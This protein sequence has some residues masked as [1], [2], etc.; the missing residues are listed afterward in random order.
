MSQTTKTNSEIS[1]A[2]SSLVNKIA[3]IEIQMFVLRDENEDLKIKMAAWNKRIKGLES[4]PEKPRTR[5]TYSAVAG[6]GLPPRPQPIDNAN[7]HT[8]NKKPEPK[9]VKILQPLYLKASREVIVMFDNANTLTTGQQVEDKALE[10]VNF[11]LVNSPIGNSSFY[12]IFLL[13]IFY[14]VTTHYGLVCECCAG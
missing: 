12:F 5:L 11:A 2:L 4:S 7:T 14:F 1:G 3:N 8:A 13:F 10:M 6:A 9:P